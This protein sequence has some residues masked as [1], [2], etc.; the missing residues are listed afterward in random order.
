MIHEVQEYFLN[1]IVTDNLGIIDNA[2]KVFADKEPHRAMSKKCI[3]LAKLHSIAVDSPKTGEV[4]E[5]PYSLRPKMYPDFMEKHDKPTYKSQSVI[6]KLF[7]QVKD[8]ASCTSPINLFTREVAKQYYDPDME[9]VGFKEYISDALDYKSEYDSKL[10]NLMDYYGI[11]TEAE[12]LNGKIL[13]MSKCFNKRRD[14]EEVNYA[15][16]SLRM[17]ARTRFN[18]GFS[19]SDSDS[20]IVYAKASAWYHVTYHYSH[21][22]RYNE[23]M[24]RSHFLSFPWCIWDKLIQIKRKAASRMSIS[25]ASFQSWIA[26]GRRILASHVKNILVSVT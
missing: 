19:D 22:D 20:H 13:K 9:V 11:E 5:V 25:G 12:I 23:G 14:M 21:W 7:R 4:V 15:V 10:G 3:E 18:K 16:K 6:G 17:E 24:D 26:F 1:Y 2:H 8:I